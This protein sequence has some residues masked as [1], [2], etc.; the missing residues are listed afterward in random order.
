[1]SKSISESKGSKE[2]FLK[3]KAKKSR[4]GFLRPNIGTIVATK[5]YAP[6]ER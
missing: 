3:S 5:V 4:R 2:F 1:M 6:G